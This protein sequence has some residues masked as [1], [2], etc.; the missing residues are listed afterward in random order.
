VRRRGKGGKQAGGRR[1]TTASSGGSQ[2]ERAWDAA[3]G[4]ELPVRVVRPCP[5]S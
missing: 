1:L 2:G 4:R 5:H 3:G